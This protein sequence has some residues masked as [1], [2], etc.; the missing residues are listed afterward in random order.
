MKFTRARRARAR[1]CGR[2]KTR[3]CGSWSKTLAMGIPAE[4]LPRIFDRF[5]RVPRENQAP[6]AGLGLAIAKEIVEA[7]GGQYR[8]AKPRRGR[9]PIQ[10]HIAACG[11]PAGMTARGEP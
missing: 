11:S 1:V 7:H 10:L 3:W 9:K 4:Y 8:R 5:F 6:G 2:T